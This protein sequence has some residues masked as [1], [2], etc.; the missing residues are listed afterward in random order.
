MNRLSAELVYRLNRKGLRR[1][2]LPFFI[3]DIENLKNE[4]KNLSCQ[5]LNHE[6]EELGWGIEILD[7]EMFGSLI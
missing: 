3:K 1:D 6:L 5:T 2:D 7:R 4:N